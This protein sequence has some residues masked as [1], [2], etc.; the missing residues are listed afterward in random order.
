MRTKLLFTN[1]CHPP[2]N[3]GLTCNMYVWLARARTSHVAGNPEL[4]YGKFNQHSGHIST[5]L[6]HIT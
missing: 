5:S 6:Y 2:A 4:A 3:A 1:V